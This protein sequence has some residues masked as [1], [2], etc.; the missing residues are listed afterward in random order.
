MASED[1]DDLFIEQGAV[2][3]LRG[4][5][6]LTLSSPAFL[7]TAVSVLPA[8]GSSPLSQEGGC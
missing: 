3:K 7:Q 8:V 6:P 5:Y 4:I 2:K 1:M